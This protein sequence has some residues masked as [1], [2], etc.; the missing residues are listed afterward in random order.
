MIS[1]FRD[2]SNHPKKNGSYIITI[3]ETEGEVVPPLFGGCD[4]S[5][6]GISERMN[7]NDSHYLVETI[8]LRLMEQDFP[9]D[10]AEGIRLQQIE[11]DNNK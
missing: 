9:E 2:V 4:L 6:A 11:L 5:S 7:I 1:I 3:S 8:R 10:F